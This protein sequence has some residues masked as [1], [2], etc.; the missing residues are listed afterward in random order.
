MKT[1]RR[2]NVQDVMEYEA[3]SRYAI[4]AGRGAPWLPY[5]THGKNRSDLRQAP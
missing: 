4:A 1:G 5:A 3:S 2:P